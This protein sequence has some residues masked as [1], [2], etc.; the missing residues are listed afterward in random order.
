MS[1]FNN[2]THFEFGQGFGQ[3]FT[4]TPNEILNDDTLSYKA[5]GIYVQILQ[6]QN[7]REHKVYMATLRKLK[8]DGETSVRNGM[9]ELIKRGYIERITLRNDKGHIT[10]CKYIVHVK[11]IENTTIKPKRDNATLDNNVLENHV[12]INKI[13]NKEN[14]KKENVDDD[15]AKQTIHSDN[16]IELY[17]TFKI[18]K[19]IMPHTLKL[20]KK[21]ADC[22]SIEVLEQVFIQASEESVIKKYNYIKTMLEDYLDNKIFTINDLVQYN[23]KFKES[24]NSKTLSKNNSKSKAPTFKTRFH[25]INES[26]SKYA[27][28]ELERILQESQKGKF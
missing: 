18:E 21:Y 25:N 6:Y 2:E 8:S 10:G 9:N 11:P 3:G 22:F 20:L 13:G 4:V 12:V 7:S 28:D 19:R 14:L 16:I 17:K 1:Y 5:L 15:D 24:K 26:F 23:Q 27:P